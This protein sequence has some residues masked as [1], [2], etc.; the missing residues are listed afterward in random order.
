MGAHQN[1][2]AE[3]PRRAD[4][5]GARAIDGQVLSQSDIDRVNHQTRMDVEKLRRAVFA[6]AARSSTAAECRELLDIVGIDL[7]VV[8]VM[9]SQSALTERERD[10]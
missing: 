2:F 3:I 5:P 10:G 8:A 7:A 6:I 4:A 1:G 9:R